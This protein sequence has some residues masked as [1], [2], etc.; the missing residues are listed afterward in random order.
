M[1]LFRRR[2]NQMPTR[3]QR[4][5]AYRPDLLALQARRVSTTRTTLLGREALRHLD[6]PR[7]I[8]EVIPAHIRAR[9]TPMEDRPLDILPIRVPTPAIRVILEQWRGPTHHHKA[10]TQEPWVTPRSTRR[11]TPDNIPHIRVIPGTPATHHEDHPRAAIHMRS[12]HTATVLSHHRII[13]AGR[14]KDLHSRQVLHMV[15]PEQ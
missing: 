1:L 12:L 3:T 9:A 14:L 13:L 5:L 7:Y 2:K 4:P 11:A 10:P 6:T 15:R 8:P